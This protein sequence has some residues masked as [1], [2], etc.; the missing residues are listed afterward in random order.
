MPLQAVSAVDAS[1]EEANGGGGAWYE[2][3]TLA[4]GAFVVASLA[5]GLLGRPRRTDKHASGLEQGIQLI[6]P[7]YGLALWGWSAYNG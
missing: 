3:W 6:R 2:S 1:G 4:V 7:R 5:V